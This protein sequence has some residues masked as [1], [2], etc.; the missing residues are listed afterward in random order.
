MDNPRGY[1]RGRVFTLP[2]PNPTH[3]HP[4]LLLSQLEH[5]VL[6]RHVPGPPPSRVAFVG[7]SPLP[8][9]SLVIASRYLP[10]AA[11]DNYI[12]GDANDHVRRRRARRAHG[13]SHL[14]RRPRHPGTGRLRRR[15]PS[16]ARGHGCRGE[17][18]RR[19]A[20]RKAHG[21]RRRAGGAERA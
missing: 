14:R 21:A 12:C 8:H 7:S 16:G 4:Y 13:V 1:D 15:L 20:P 6:V 18:A 9:N 11:F 19:R 5:G 2:D 3:C 17:G 10:T